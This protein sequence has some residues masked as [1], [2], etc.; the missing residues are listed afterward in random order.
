[1][2]NSK[3]RIIGLAALS[4]MLFVMVAPHQLAVAQT[5]T[6]VFINEIHYDNESTDTGEAIEIAG[7]AS[8]D[9]SVYSL[10]LY[11][12]SNG[13]VYNTIALTG[14]IPNQENGFGTVNFLFPPNGLQNG[15]PDGIALAQGSTL[16]QFLSY[17]G[18]FTAVGGVADGVLST[19]IGVQESGST[20]VGESLQL[21][22]TGT[23]YEDFSWTGPI[24]NTYDAVNTGQSFAQVGDAA[25]TVA[26]TTPADGATDV[27]VDSNVII[28]FSEAVDVTGTW[29]DLTCTTSGSVTATAT[30]GPVTFTLDPDSDLANSETCT[31]TVFASQVT[32]QDSDDPPNGM[33]ADFQAAFTTES[34]A[35]SGGWVINEIHAD[36]DGSIAGDA[37]GDGVREAS[38]DE[39]VE[40]V[41][42]TGADVDISG[43]TLSDNDTPTVFTFPNGTVI[44]DQCAIVLFGGGTPAGSFGGAFVFTDDGT[45]GTG[46]GNSGD[47]IIFTDGTNTI[48]TASYGSEGGD[49]QSLTRDPDI[50]GSDSPFTKHT[51]AAGA[52]GA[53]FSPG[54]QVDGTPFPGCTVPV[55]TLLLSEIVV[56][57]TAGEFVE[58]YNPNGFAVDL[59]DVYLT[60][61]TFAN[62]GTYY[63]NIVT[64]SNAGGGGF[65]DFHARFPDGASIGAGEYQ[66][67]ALAGSA[68]FIATYGIAPTYELFDDASND[69]EQVMREALPGSINNQGGL[70]N[71][72]EVV[73][74]YTWN[75]Q[76][77]LVTDLDYAVW[78]DKDEAVDKSG[79]SIDGPD[80]DSDPSTY[81]ADTPIASQ[82]VIAGG[83]HSGGNAWQR[84]DLTEGNEVKTGGN[85]A[86]G[87]DETS[88]D[89]SAT[90]CEFTPTPGAESVCEP[91]T[92]PL[93]CVDTYTFTF[94]H[95]IQGS[96]ATTPLFGQEVIVEAVVVGD[97]QAND[98]D[99]TDLAGFYIQEE[100][101]QA[102]GD[103]NTSEGLFVYDF[104]NSAV[105]VQPGDLVRVRGISTEF[106][107]QT[108]IDVTNGAVVVCS[109]DQAGLVTPTPITFPLPN[110]QA[111]LEALEGMLVTPA[112]PMTVIEYFNLDRFGVVDVATERLEQPTD[113]AEPGA[114]AA[115]IAEFNDARRIRL[116]DGSQTQNPFPVTLPDGQLDYSDAFGGGDTLDNIVGV[117]SWIRPFP[118]GTADSYA[119]QL[120]QLPTFT[121]SNPRPAAPNVGGDLNV[122]G[123]NVL[124]YFT[125]L[126]S[127][128]ADTPA[129]FAKQRDKIVAALL[130]MDADV[131]G[132][133]EIENNFAAGSASAV[134]DL[135]DGLNAAA[136]AGTYAYIDPGANVGTDEITVAIIYQPASV[137]PV[138]NLAILD[139]ADFVNPFGAADARNRPALA[140]T[141]AQNGTGER[142]TVVVNHFKSKGSSDIGGICTDGNPANDLPDCD[143]GDGQGYF[144]ATRT[145]AAQALVDWLAT[146][147]T[148]SGDPDVLLVGDYNAYAQEDPI[149][150]LVNAGYADLLAAFNGDDVYTY[151]FDGTTGYLD[152]GFAS[153]TL[154]EQVVDTKPWNINS[155][156][157]DAFE[158]NEDFDAPGNLPL[159]YAPT[160][161]R[162]SDH[163]PVIVGLLLESGPR[164]ERFLLVD[165][166]SD[167]VIGELMDG[168]TVNLAEYPFIN[169]VAVTDPTT[170]GSVLFT[171][172]GAPERIENV[173]P[174]A[175]AGDNNGNYRHWRID[176]GTYTI[177]A[178]PFS[179]Q[180]AGGDAGTPKAITINIIDF[181][182]PPVVTGFLLVDADTDQVIGPVNDGDTIDLSQ[183]GR[184]N[185][186]AVASDN[187]E[188]VVFELNG[189]VARVENV[190]PYAIAGDN[191]GNYRPWRIDAGVYT[192]EATPYTGNG[193]S[194]V[195]GDTQAITITLVE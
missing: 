101:S 61:A 76:S 140:Q 175:L 64:G 114:A 166:R 33:D 111:D 134:A 136:G 184:I 171:V 67:V 94:L 15:E 191:N 37:N 19:D 54:T 26:S 155:D 144:N 178:T 118:G 181:V 22:G 138:G 50:T 62:G 176:P 69:G 20:Q 183:Y 1:M 107:D 6:P 77:D 154:L 177:E 23:V 159:W 135:V 128:G 90:W 70:T 82:D 127:R 115:A 125:T 13:A 152:Y 53:L 59:S 160:P 71:S 141:F 145:A 146:D 55:P 97:F 185:L 162:S 119:I 137:T 103:P 148:N 75:G 109:S 31:L 12:G 189:R 188:S 100:D 87:H 83:S 116:D 25:P 36:P 93:N 95:E 173:V 21:T 106:Q 193:R 96:G 38:A 74:L 35:P 32:D 34:A 51:S 86:A 120:T 79:V 170:V 45:I 7:P 113:A 143:Q 161:Y 126:G 180:R 194:G 73:V 89:L 48:A 27:P 57:P 150:V 66:T 85:G 192:I 102:D 9:L 169:V 92:P 3:I 123:F 122:V 4:I 124:N 52:N 81:L 91:V 149:D 130:E 165:S 121:D 41:N 186:V 163:D 11:N 132:L 151:V 47:D 56:T 174:Y 80:A 98:G 117:L 133:I 43:W 110:G 24:A 190:A 2:S 142:F 29:F 14:I 179:E 195:A 30:G 182:P 131:V 40:V 42:N 65:G 172:N 147:P 153:Q 17:E 168:D 157:P 58:I 104:L 167:T 129:E 139:T 72:G 8:T 156:E 28:E 16:I 10:V 99:A 112:Q 164:V 78:G 49:N 18:T 88:E 46:L 63:Y 68:G 39:F 60:D 158:Y 5:A 84:E 44:P 105:D 108:Q 187:T